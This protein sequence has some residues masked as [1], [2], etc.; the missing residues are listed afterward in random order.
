MS[1]QQFN[2]SDNFRCGYVAII[3]EPNVGKSTLMNGLMGQKLSIVTPKPQTTRHKVLG[4]LSTNEHQVIF[5][6]TPG[7]IKPKYLLHEAMMAFASSALEDADVV[8]FMIDATDPK[9]G[10][11]LTHEEAFSRLKGLQKPV[12]LVINKADLVNKVEI[13]PVI[14][15]YSKAFAFKEIFP[16]SALKLDGTADLLKAIV[17][18][19]PQHQPFYPLDIVSEQSE[20]FFVAEII[21]EKIFEKYQQEIPYSTT[22]D[23]AEF[24]E[25]EAGKTFISADIYVERDSQK[26]ILIGKGGEALKQ[27]GRWARKDI[28]TFLHHPVFL[29]MR[30]KVRADWREDKAWLARLGYKS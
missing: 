5:L 10:V 3:G 2:I 18:E 20:R 14:D 16:V 23:I 1:E 4:L 6:D 28:E 13:L 12:I 24:K 26:G 15:F 25:R 17:R 9:V 19:L 29:E 11:D 27:I 7:I 21:R 22:V 30:V 8:L